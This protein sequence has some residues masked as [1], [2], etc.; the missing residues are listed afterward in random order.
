MSEREPY[1]KALRFGWLTRFY[2]RAVAVLL[3]EQELKRRLL[4]QAGIAR[5]HRVLDVGCGTAAL[6]LMAQKENGDALIV[7][8][9]GDLEALALAQRKASVAGLSLR[10]CAGLAQDLPFRSSA[11]DRIVSG[12]FFHHLTR[13]AKRAVLM[14]VRDALAGGGELHVLDWG[15]AQDRLMR[16]MFFLVQLLDGFATTTDSVRGRLVTF[17]T[18]AGFV[19]AE[20]THRERSTLGTLSLYRAAVGRGKEEG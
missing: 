15:K 18:E 2:D 1:L 6:T 3:K 10:V 11:F 5:G 17:M 20:E 12:L 14:A 4:R 8:I 13:P 9:D 16:L 7:G 19:D